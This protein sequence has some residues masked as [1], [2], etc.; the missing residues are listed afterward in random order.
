MTDEELAKIEV[1]A[2]RAQRWGDAETGMADAALELIAEIRR[3]RM[4]RQLFEI[5]TQ[6]RANAICAEALSHY[7]VVPRR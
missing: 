7:D 2:E 5:A 4:D 3:M 6:Q 1:S